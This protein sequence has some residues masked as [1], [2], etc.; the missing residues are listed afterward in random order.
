MHFMDAFRTN[1][2]TYRN[3]HL[4]TGLLLRPVV[5]ADFVAGIET[6]TGRWQIVPFAQ[7]LEF[8]LGGQQNSLTRPALLRSQ[9]LAGHLEQ[10]QG[11]SLVCS[12]LN[13]RQIRANLVEVKTGLL[14]LSADSKMLAV[15]LTALAW[16]MLWKTQNLQIDGVSAFTEK[17]G[18]SYEDK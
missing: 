14:W 15:P 3:L 2:L 4:D 1:Q 10:L 18:I 11:H 7:V 8:E 5:G 12:L 6:N 9:T 17:E 13:K 16:V